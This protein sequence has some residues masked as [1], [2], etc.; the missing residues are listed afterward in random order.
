MIRGVGVDLVAVSRMRT[1]LDGETANRFL[2]K[3]LTPCERD[4][5]ATKRAEMQANYLAKRFAAKEAVVK[6]FGTGFRDGISLQDI[7]I[8]NDELGRPWVKLCGVLATKVCAEDE[9]FLLSLSDDGD[10]AIAY[11]VFANTKK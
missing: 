4:T 2:E 11:V 3:V 8:C 9:S 1:I 7:E 6:A 10:Y 5:F